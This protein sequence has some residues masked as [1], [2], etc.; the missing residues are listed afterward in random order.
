MYFILLDKN[1]T[2]SEK[3]KVLEYYSESELGDM[4]KK[5]PSLEYFRNRK[6]C[7]CFESQ[8]HKNIKNK[9]G[10]VY[11]IGLKGFLS[12]EYK[13]RFMNPPSKVKVCIQYLRQVK[14]KD[15]LKHIN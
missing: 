15:L 2:K 9:A 6:G 13:A 8:H 10:N 11:F 7:Y 12:K 5:Y 1:Y 3:H 4:I 14:I